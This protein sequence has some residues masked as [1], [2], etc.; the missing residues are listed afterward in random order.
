[1]ISFKI[2]IDTDE[3]VK[4]IDDKMNEIV[5][6]IFANSQQIIVNQSII[7]E[8][9]LLK[10]GNVNRQLLDKEI[11]YS[12][13]YADTIEFGRMPGSMPPIS[14]IEGWLGRKLGIQDEKE[15]KRIA[16]AIARDIERNGTE[17]RPFLQ[18]AIEQTKAKMKR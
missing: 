16:F 12:A 4:A 5:D 13:P 2:H 1:M 15:K 8:G 6:D 10:S 3:I 9:T 7:D 17:P 11:V 14:S 18:P